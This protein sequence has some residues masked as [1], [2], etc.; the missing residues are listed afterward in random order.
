VSEE[1]YQDWFVVE[2]I[3]HG[4]TQISEP[5]HE[6]GVKSY[7]VE[8][9][10]QVAV[11]DTGLGVGDFYALV[12]ELSDR[13][14]IVL[15]THGHWDHFGGSHAFAQVLIHPAEAYALRRGFPNAMYQPLFTPQRLRDGTL[16]AWFDPETASIPPV[17]PTGE[18]NHGDVID[19]GGRELEVFH[20][21]GHSQ[22]GVSLLDR[23]TA[24][25]FAGD[26]INEGGNWLFLPRSDAAAFRQSIH[27]LA[28]LADDLVAIYPSHGK[29][30]LRP[31][32]L[33]EARDAFEEVWA[34][35]APDRRV[36]W[37]IGFPERVPVDVH[38]FGEFT[39]LLGE[40]RY[41][42]GDG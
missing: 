27:L 40:G 28:E 18:L 42:E 10:R 41:G 11:I 12:A 30:P 4:I 38:D 16:P 34:G 2:R 14:P 5:L 39:F 37:D 8:G 35:R 21:P 22:G 1:R 24:T 23:A 9:E 31:S 17:E 26:V 29:A 32:L 25:L 7:I 33:I 19:L 3:G 13:D 15:Q 6:E 36:R 20:T